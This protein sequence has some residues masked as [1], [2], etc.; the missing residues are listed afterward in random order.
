MSLPRTYHSDDSEGVRLDTLVGA[1]VDAEQMK[2]LLQEI[3]TSLDSAAEDPEGIF[4]G[5]D[6]AEMRNMQSTTKY[7][8][9]RC[10]EC[11]EA[12]NNE[13]ETIKDD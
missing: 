1:R 8:I 9:D 12:I 6:R 4:S 11:I 13:L 3:Y 7:L 2:R 5:P 10:D